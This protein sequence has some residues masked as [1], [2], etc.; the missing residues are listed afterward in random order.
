MNGCEVTDQAFHIFLCV[1]FSGGLS[2]KRGHG[3]KTIRR[4]QFVVHSQKYY[5][6]TDL[7]QEI[8]QM[9]QTCF[10]THLVVRGLRSYGF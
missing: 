7:Y 6:N 8:I 1:K 10:G 2:I 9:I 5:E 4:V 3:M